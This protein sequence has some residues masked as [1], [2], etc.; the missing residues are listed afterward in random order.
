MG[1]RPSSGDRGDSELRTQVALLMVERDVLSTLYR[2]GHSIDNGLEEEWLDCFALDGAFDVRYRVGVRPSRRFEGR[3]DLARFIAAHSR[4]PQR[5]HKHLLFEPL[6][7]VDGDRARVRSYFTRLD[8]DD[9]GTPFVRAFGRYLDE[10][11]RGSD[12]KWRFA[13]RIVEVEA[14]AVSPDDRN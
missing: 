5:W 1:E 10:L 8:A 6:I 3:D 7:T 2:Y 12:G 4:A 13:E 14:V 9:D 11:V